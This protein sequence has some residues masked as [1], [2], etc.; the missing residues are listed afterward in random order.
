VAL[1]AAVLATARSSMTRSLVRTQMDIGPDSVTPL[2]WLIAPPLLLLAQWKIAPE[3][4]TYARD[5]A[6]E[7]ANPLIAAIER[8]RLSHGRY[9][10]TLHSLWEDYDPSVIGIPRYLYEPHGDS[11]NLLF[12][13]PTFEFGARVIVVWNPRDEQVATSHNSDLLEFTGA[14]LEQRRGYL[15]AHAATQPHWKWFVFD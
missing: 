8:F 10:L 5:R 3:A 6:I 13:A 14:E 7:H 12:E 9:P 15:K 2:C 4:T 1:G 11:Y